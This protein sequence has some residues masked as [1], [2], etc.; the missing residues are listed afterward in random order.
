MVLQMGNVEIVRAALRALGH[1]DRDR[2]AA[3]FAPEAEWHN[4]PSFPGPSVC[5]GLDQIV[6]FW[7]GMAEGFGGGGNEIE[8]ITEIDG[9]VVVGIRSW[10]SGRLSGAPVNVQYAAIFELV[11]Q[12]ITRVRVHG[13][14][15]EALEAVRLSGD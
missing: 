10:G 15:A 13:N 8:Q 3:L 1:H 4:T 12:H 7:E 5:V 11:D 6:D 9:Q 2:A 14:Y